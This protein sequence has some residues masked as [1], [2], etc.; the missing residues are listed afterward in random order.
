MAICV[1]I[2]LSLVICQCLKIWSF[3]WFYFHSIFLWN[4]LN[5]RKYGYFWSVCSFL[6]SCVQFLVKCVLSGEAKG[7]HAYITCVSHLSKGR[8]AYRMRVSHLSKGRCVLWRCAPLL[9]NMHKK[10]KACK[11]VSMGMLL[12][13]THS[14]RAG[15]RSTAWST[16][17][18][19][20]SK[21]IDCR[22]F[23]S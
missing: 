23:K 13:P 9:L 14:V 12:A 5:V 4:M 3:V 6:K 18:L 22:G 17:C 21:H 7:R 2:R 8:R 11:S 16:S 10:K 15:A 20:S 19:K 1:K